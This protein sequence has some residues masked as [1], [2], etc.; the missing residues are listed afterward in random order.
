M[1]NQTDILRVVARNS[2]LS[3]LQVEEVFSQLAPLR[4]E[5]KTLASY[6][7]KNKHISLMD[8]SVAEDFFT[9]ELDNLLLEGKADVAIHSAKDL[10]YPLPSGLELYSLTEAK[11]RSDSLI[12]SGNRTLKQLPAGARVGT[13]SLNRRNELQK[14]RPDLTVVSIRGTIEERIAQVDNGYIDALIVATCALKRLRLDNRI[15]EELPFAT[16]ALQGHLAVVGKAGRPEIK[17]SFSSFDIRRTYGKVTLVGF[18]PGNPDLLTIAGDKALQQA[19][20]IYHD[21]LVDI[22]FLAKYEGQKIYV[23]KRRNKHSHHQDEINELVYQS[24]IAGHNVVRIKGG[25]PMIFAHGREEIDYL[26]SRFVEVSVVP[27]ISSGIALA[28]YTHIPLTH[29]G[30]SSSVAFV[31]GHGGKDAPIPNADTLV[32]YMAGAKISGIARKL[33]S[34]GRD[35]G[36]PAALVYNVSLPGQ[37]TYYSTLKEL[38]F[39]VV[40]YP[41][42]ILIIV[43]QVVSFENNRIPTQKVLLTG[44]TAEDYTGAENV[45]HTP[46]ITIKKTESAY[47]QQ[48]LEEQINTYQ[49]IIFTSRYAVR[50]FFETLDKLQLDM[51]TLSTLKIA[52]VGKTTTAEL[53]KYRFNPDIESTTESAEGLVE[54]FAA[55]K[56]NGCNILLPRSDK[57]LKYLSDELIAM[58]NY[59]TDIP[60]YE[61]TFNTD[62]TKQELTAFSKIIFSSPSGVE[63]FQRLYGKLPEG[64][65]LVAKG[66]TTLNKII[67]TSSQKHN[68]LFPK[69]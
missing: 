60:V 55:N 14:L 42:P 45:V 35:A 4:Y 40:R 5:L 48:L 1:N 63:A 10:P 64:I 19:D 24:A 17:A 18:G 31:T 49:W 62:V 65:Q 41:T 38:Q 33:I 56:I 58:G 20:I 8:A 26:Q 27:G 57:G 30:I 21:D 23:G 39:S 13:S 68:C 16:H 12:S 28:S 29:R 43:G 69:R 37:K 66:S 32:Y 50:F 46:L 11:D 53:R 54:Y 22:D 7:D 52:S 6:G 15:A 34:A 44:T 51:R 9:R 36:T 67:T 2:P 59:I 3:L 61:N 47:L 25:D